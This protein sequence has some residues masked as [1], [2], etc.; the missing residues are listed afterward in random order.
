MSDSPRKIE[1]LER[2]VVHTSGYISD[3]PVPE[4]T[5]TCHICG[6]AVL[7]DKCLSCG[8][9]LVREQ[10]RGGDTLGSRDL[11]ATSR[12]E[13]DPGDVQDLLA[14]WEEAAQVGR[15]PSLVMAVCMKCGKEFWLPLT[16]IRQVRC[17]CSGQ[18]ISN[19]RRG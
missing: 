19:P 12:P 9:P 13:M 1:I 18:I 16:E 6:A 14:A 4:G 15:E 17:S 11:W 8:E 10:R 3:R 2:S 5:P 7:G